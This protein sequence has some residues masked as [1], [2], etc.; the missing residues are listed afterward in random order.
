MSRRFYVSSI[1]GND[2]NGDGTRKFKYATI[3]KLI[4]NKLKRINDEVI[5]DLDEGSYVIPNALFNKILA[6]GNLKLRGKG[7]NTRVTING[8]I[9]DGSSSNT[10]VVLERLS[11]LQG[12]YVTNRYSRNNSG[13]YDINYKEYIVTLRQDLVCNNVLFIREEKFPSLFRD[14]G[15]IIDYNVPLSTYAFFNSRYAD[16]TL[17]NCTSTSA[18]IPTVTT[19][20]YEYKFQDILNHYENNTVTVNNSYNIKFDIYDPTVTEE[21]LHDHFIIDDFSFCNETNTYD[22]T[23]VANRQLSVINANNYLSNEYK[24]SNP[25]HL[26]DGIGIY[27]GVNAI[28]AKQVIGFDDF[29]LSLVKIKEYIDTV[30]PDVNL[31]AIIGSFSKKSTDNNL[32]WENSKVLRMNEFDGAPSNLDT[33]PKIYTSLQADEQD[34]N[35]IK[36]N[37]NST[38][39]SKVTVVNDEPLFDGTKIALEEDATGLLAEILAVDS[40]EEETPE[41]NS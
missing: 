20:Y 18:C 7:Y 6:N 13:N 19:V 25:S 28:G 4:T 37:F 31:S 15:D 38:F 32:Y 11:L 21:H 35:D 41:E 40:I 33:I 8:G 2:T 23:V 3:E 34:I 12:D 9:K 10:T 36:N 39:N 26:Y 16:I 14:N 24:I 27:Y 29:K 1:T 5:I 22:Q 17:N 30:I